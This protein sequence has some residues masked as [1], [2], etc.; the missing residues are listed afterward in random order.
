[1]KIGIKR[2]GG[3]VEISLQCGGDYQSIELSDRLVEAASRGTVTIDLK[4]R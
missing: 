1:M 4:A 3:S 2:L